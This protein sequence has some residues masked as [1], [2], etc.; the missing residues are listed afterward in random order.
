MR[1]EL[2]YSQKECLSENKYLYNGKELQN[3]LL[4]GINLDVYDYSSRYYDPQIARWTTIDPLADNYYR[5]T[6]YNYTI[7][8]PLRFIDIDGREVFING[9]LS[10]E[11]LRQLQARVGGDITLSL[12]DKGKVTYTTN[13]DNKLRGYAKRMAGM[14]NDNSI[15]VNLVTTNKNETSTGNLMVGGAFMGNKVTKATDANT[16][17]FANQ[18]INPNVLGSADAHT[19]TSGKMIM[20][21]V[22]EAYSGAQISQK[23]GVG[24]GPATQS[25]V[26]NPN[27]VYSRAHNN[28]TSQSTV[29][30]T[31]YD[32]NGKITTDATQSVRA[33]WSVMRWF[34][35][36]VIQTLP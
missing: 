13:T 30:Q 36:K 29:Y 2:I 11:A 1:N 15:T 31:L 17:I 33:E 16:K 26:D 34:K 14:I 21:E 18:E 20:H 6:P 19:K 27:S 35:S 32:K 25:D 23:S 22:T 8:N 5:W 12:D 10:N 3:N 4:G 24:V 28:A 7:N 9:T